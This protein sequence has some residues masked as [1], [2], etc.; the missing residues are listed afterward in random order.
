MQSG[1]CQRQEI[2]CLLLRAVVCLPLRVH[3]IF[4][5]L[6]SGKSTAVGM[7]VR[8]QGESLTTWTKQTRSSR[9]EWETEQLWEQKSQHTK[10][11]YHYYN[12]LVF[13]F[14]RGEDGTLCAGRAMHC[15]ACWKK[16]AV[17]KMLAGFWV[18]DR[19]DQELTEAT[20]FRL[21]PPS[22]LQA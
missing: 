14:C 12:L 11:C 19:K 1:S 3:R 21:S 15:K 10:Y 9:K 22:W 18:G 2:C 8:G 17:K 5:L 16:M 13:I 7:K 20:V 4:W 6:I